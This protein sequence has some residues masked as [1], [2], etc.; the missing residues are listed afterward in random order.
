MLAVLLA[1][2]FSWLESSAGIPL[3]AS[4]RAF[5]SSAQV[6][7]GCGT[8]RGNRIIQNVCVNGE[9][10]NVNGD[11]DQLEADAVNAY[12][13]EHNLPLGDANLVYTFGRLDLRDAIRANMMAL[14]IGIITKPE[15]TR[16]PHEAALYKWL[17]ALIQQNEI[18]EYSGALAEYQTWKRDPCSYQLDPIIA[19]QYGLS[20]DGKLA[21]LPQSV[22]AAGPPF[23]PAASYFVAVGIKASYGKLSNAFSY[24]PAIVGDT[25][26][27]LGEIWGIGAASGVVPAAISAYVF[28]MPEVITALFPYSINAGLAEVLVDAAA[29]SEVSLATGP[30][31]II[32]LCV[33]TGVVA[34]LELADQQ[35]QLKDLKALND[36][37]AQAQNTPPDLIAFSRDSNGLGMLKLHE[38]LI[39]Q[40]LPDVE[41]HLYPPDHNPGDPVFLVTPRGGTSAPYEAFGHDDWKRA[42]W[43][44]WTSGG[45]FAQ[46]CD[47]PY[48]CTE[49]VDFSGSIRFVDWS[50]VDWFASRGK[51]IP[52]SG[53]G[54]FVISK[55]VPAPTDVPCP[56]DPKTGITPPT[57]LSKCSS[58]VASQIQY[59]YAG[60][61]YTMALTNLP[62]FS[63]IKPIYFNQN[64]PRQNTIVTASGTPAPAIS[65]A[66][67]SS[68]PAGVYFQGSDV[69][70]NGDAQFQF[71]GFGSGTPGTYPVTLQAQNAHGTAQQTFQLV[72]SPQLQITSP[73]FLNVPWGQPV[74]FQVTT[75][76][77]PRPAL[78]I[79]P[80]LLAPF[81]GLSF[82]DNGDGTAT[83]SGATKAGVGTIRSGAC[84]TLNGQTT[85]SG[86][87]AKSAQGSVT[88]PFALG[89]PS[90]PEP[91]LVVSSATFI[92]GVV[93]SF[94][95]TTTGATT[96]V[97]FGFG[98][99]N[100]SWLHFQDNGD[101]TGI[102]SGTPPVETSGTYTFN[103]S[104]YPNV[105]APPSGP[106]TL[107]TLNVIGRPQFTSKN[108]AS[109]TVGQ[110]SSF[111]ISTNQ[112]SGP[113][114]EIG[115][116]PE[117]LA[118]IDNGNGTATVT[119]TPAAGSGGV[120]TLQL[121]ATNSLGTGMQALNL[122]VNETPL[123]TTTP[124]QGNKGIS[125]VNFSI[126]Q[127]NSFGFSVSGYPLLS[128]APAS[129]SQS[130]PGYVPGVQFTI[131][132]QPPYVLP[133]DLS[134][135][136]LNPQGYNT[137]TLTLSGNPSPADTGIYLVNMAATNGVG[138]G[139]GMQ[140]ILNIAAPG[141]V[142]G[143]GVVNCSD[144]NQVK[145]SFG[146]YRIQAGYNP[147][148]DLNND[149]VVDALDLAIVTPKLSQGTVC[150]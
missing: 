121:S 43:T 96:P 14:L 64:A 61:Q 127:P 2:A 26:M 137:G 101:G 142:N 112:S 107:F 130:A 91:Q 109:F 106:V 52:S 100:P 88:Q 21:C 11:L 4:A 93:N 79:D 36:Q 19:A 78:S 110:A 131:Q 24:F 85:C 95:V 111:T 35:T 117:G 62:A 7:Q 41:S 114:A 55:A 46:H 80:T 89:V 105:N 30:A 144:V 149:G 67:G 54:T 3:G 118:F 147:R 16:T 29:L 38:T 148:A 69:L 124:L 12:L 102:L 125:F 108:S 87:T 51:L 116:L 73:A 150:P 15:Q 141:D 28:T 63:N 25:Q 133:A 18:A 42:P 83:I 47:N 27:N 34:G 126:G 40:T 97:A 50:G 6:V 92:A 98:Y 74:S 58:Y 140:L 104:P 145:A 103:L 113:I 84:I 86:I 5:Q 17:Q 49:G 134:Y 71:L 60:N 122:Q 39:S 75:T 37:L 120:K 119:G 82:H 44:A 115:G 68:V 48:T 65:L 53:E 23:V 132:G 1:P 136:N 45:W 138:N 90:P 123:F 32:L 33:L 57:D 139:A 99:D 70:G 31:A 13:T 66:K 8:G 129:Q 143:D 9:P 56:A 81:P 72:I 146:L 22:A 94:K 77:F 20:Y 128:S 59:T 135:S 10:Y 76:G